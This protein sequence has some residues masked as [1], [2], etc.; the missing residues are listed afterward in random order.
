MSN[1]R[2]YELAKELNM[3]SSELVEKLKGAG[4][5]I[6]NYMSTLDSGDVARAK[7][8]LAGAT[9]EVFEEKRIKP[10]V[11]R[12]RKKIVAKVP[13]ELQAEERAV[14]TEV[15]ASAEEAVSGAEEEISEVGEKVDK[16]LEQKEEESIEAGPELEKEVKE[17]VGEEVEEEGKAET[18]S[19]VSEELGKEQ[20]L[21]LKEEAVVERKVKKG[22]PK[23]EKK[24]KAK[25]KSVPAK[26][27]KLG[28]APLPGPKAHEPAKVTPSE[29]VI[30]PDEKADRIKGPR[31][32]R[33]EEVEDLTPKREF[34]R[35]RREIFERKDLYGDRE[36][37]AVGKTKLK[38]KGKLDKKKFRQTEITTPKAIKRR[39]KVPSVMSVAELAKSMGVKAAEL[40]KKLLEIGRAS[41]RERV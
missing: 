26:I 34:H 4:L 11:I 41:C 33:K 23:V 32:R 7:D 13:E 37:G 1:V 24:K 25:P 5:S 3:N 14:E 10:T 17:E 29:I 15:A 38:A 18:L 35:R 21:E 16:E 8:Y 22:E 30:P 40:I 31:K 9:S 20:D 28:E 39:I 27:I 36:V 2:V 19:T 12:R 6:N